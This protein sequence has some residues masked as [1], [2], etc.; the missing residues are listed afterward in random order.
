MFPFKLGSY[1]FYLP[2]DYGELTLKQFFELRNSPG[3]LLSVLSI[4]SGIEKE[5]WELCKDL[6]LEYKLARCLEFLYQPFEPKK[7]I[8][9]DSMEINGK[10]YDRPKGLGVETWGQKLALEQEYI[11]IQKEDKS[12]FDMY[13]FALALYFQPVYTGEKYKSELVDKI[14][15]DI[16]N[17]RLEEAF[18]IAAFFLS[19][20]SKFRRKKRSDYLIPLARKKHVRALTDSRSSDRLERFTLWRRVLIRILKKF[21]KWNTTQSS[22]P[23]GM[24][25]SKQHFKGSYTR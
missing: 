4:L 18:P 25:Q 20:Y 5:K 19:N 12:E 16:M 6:D 8:L 13:P 3:D 23:S 14:L 17:C 22:L 24:N 10:Y 21:F 9:P 11:R 15:P 1:E 7:Y 2:Q